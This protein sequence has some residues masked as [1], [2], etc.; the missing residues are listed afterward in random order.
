MN[1]NM[2]VLF[3]SAIFLTCFYAYSNDEITTVSNK[4]KLEYL[5]FEADRVIITKEETDELLT[6][7]ITITQKTLDDLYELALASNRFIVCSHR[8]QQEYFPQKMRSISSTL[9]Y[10]GIGG[11]ASLLA[12]G[13]LVWMLFGDYMD[14]ILSFKNNMGALFNNIK[15]LQKECAALKESYEKL[16][17]VVDSAKEKVE[18]LLNLAQ[19][20]HAVNNDNQTLKKILTECLEREKALKNEVQAL[21]IIITKLIEHKQIS[22]PE[23]AQLKKECPSLLE[24]PEALTAEKKN[25]LVKEY[26]KSIS[27]F[28]DKYDNFEVL[29]ASDKGLAWLEKNYPLYY[30]MVSSKL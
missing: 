10:M 24:K 15:E 2:A 18:K 4:E 12:G 29:C 8:H 1:K 20:T 14:L 21:K 22:D 25:S 28:G 13:G 5:H 11:A 19:V 3:F 30:D 23:L 17:P 6:T 7:K 26:N 27:F 9:L 16:V